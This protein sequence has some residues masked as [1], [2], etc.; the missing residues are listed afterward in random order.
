MRGRERF[1]PTESERAYSLRQHTRD[2]PSPR[3]APSSRAIQHAG[4]GRVECRDHREVACL[5][6]TSSLGS[7]E[8]SATSPWQRPALSAAVTVAGA[9]APLP[10]QSASGAS[11][12]QLR[13]TAQRRMRRDL[14]TFT[15][16]QLRRSSSCTRAPIRICARRRVRVVCRSC[17]TSTRRRIVPAA[18]RSTWRRSQAKATGRYSSSRPSSDTPTHGTATVRRSARW[19]ARTLRRTTRSRSVRMK[20]SPQPAA[21]LTRRQ[22]LST[23]RAVASS[24]C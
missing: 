14:E 21:S 16:E 1:K 9:Q 4:P 5:I 8:S 20:R 7:H 6:P 23:I 11:L 17:S 3:A 18:Q 19:L 2:L 15:R 12:D 13:A 10:A 24:T 22:T